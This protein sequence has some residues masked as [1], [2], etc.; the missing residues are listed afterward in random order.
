MCLF[1]ES[2]VRGRAYK[3]ERLRQLVAVEIEV[4][5][6][7]T[8]AHVLYAPCS[9]ASTQ[10]HFQDYNTTRPHVNLRRIFFSSHNVRREMCTVCY[11]APELMEERERVKGVNYTRSRT[12]ACRPCFAKQI[13]MPLCCYAAGKF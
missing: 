1:Q 11:R 8:L 9:W 4:R 6:L 10:Q 3:L 5:L 2:V 12:R 7:G 13:I